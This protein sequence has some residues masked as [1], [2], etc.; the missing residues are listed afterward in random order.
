MKKK[1]LW[2]L[3]GFPGQSDIV[4]SDIPFLSLL[5]DHTTLSDSSKE[6]SGSWDQASDL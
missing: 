4:A 2:V 5:I 1:L 6:K 3:F